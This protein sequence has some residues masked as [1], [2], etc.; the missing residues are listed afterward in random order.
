MSSRLAKKAQNKRRE[1]YRSDTVENQPDADDKSD[2]LNSPLTSLDS[3][4]SQAILP[5]DSTPA[6]PPETPPPDTAVVEEI[7]RHVSPPKL[8][9]RETRTRKVKE[10]S[11]IIDA[12]T[13]GAPSSVNTSVKAETSRSE[14]WINCDLCRGQRQRC[15]E[16]PSGSSP[17][18]PPTADEDEDRPD[19]P[20]CV[21]CRKRGQRCT[22]QIF[23]QAI[24][25]RNKPK[26]TRGKPADL[27]VTRNQV[28]TPVEKPMVKT[29]QTRGKVQEKEKE[30]EKGKGKEKEK[31]KDR[32]KEKE[33]EKEKEKKPITRKVTTKPDESFFSHLTTSRTRAKK[34][35]EPE[36]TGASGKTGNI[37]EPVNTGEPL[38][39]GNVG[40]SGEPVKN[41][42]TG[43]SGSSSGL[44]I[45]LTVP[46]AITETRTNKGKGK[47]ESEETK[48]VEESKETTEV[49]ESKVEDA[50]DIFGSEILEDDDVKMKHYESDNF[51]K[52]KKKKDKSL[53]K[54]KLKSPSFTSSDESSTS[55]EEVIRPTK[56]K[57]QKG[58][59]EFL[60]E[61][62]VQNTEELRSTI[63]S[64]HIVETAQSDDQKNHD[65]IMIK[66][67]KGKNKFD[68][69]VENTRSEK[70]D[71]EKEIGIKSKVKGGKSDH[72]GHI[73]M[74]PIA[75]PRPSGQGQAA[76]KKKIPPPTPTQ[77]T[78]PTSI[79]S[80]VSAT[81]KQLQ[82]KNKTGA[83]EG[84]KEVSKKRENVWL[85]EW[86]MT[87][88][89]QEEYDK[90]KPQREEAAKRRRL[91]LEQHPTKDHQASKDA[92]KMARLGG[93]LI[94][95]PEAIG[96][97]TNG[98]FGQMVNLLR[99]QKT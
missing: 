46:H 34:I 7:A 68:F 53:N 24:R 87:P 50:E 52:K 13:P 25:D 1:S 31:E 42:D 16:P 55:E 5:D 93:P 62:E 9:R 23:P 10:D 45:K 32:G 3:L 33:Q 83:K 61:F 56:S 88:E 22:F 15:E 26:G 71:V 72:E 81:L 97:H 48:P 90:S 85:D 14:I 89:E 8:Q 49:A 19:Q 82:E 77:Q 35:L 70:M 80:A 28:T 74:K 44:K 20:T 69:M 65:D 39:T 38:I 75:R 4:S 11:T 59:E 92:Q 95:V 21:K 66:K 36:K 60:P 76:I 6:P 43:K 67:K 17:S 94:R 18:P 84:E 47:K 2:S 91:W 41:G 54:R 30:K 40:S 51:E 37:G 57:R 98:S 64:S 27:K 29:V 12:S 63:G 73:G 79:L 86:Q 78:Q 58:E 99:A 96:V